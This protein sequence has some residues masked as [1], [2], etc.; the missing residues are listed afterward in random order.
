VK[1]YA[2]RHSDIARAIA[3]LAPRVLPIGAQIAVDGPASKWYRLRRLD[4]PLLAC[5]EVECID[6]ELWAHLSVSGRGHIP[7][8]DQLRW[9][10]ELLLG[11]RKAIQV[12]P[13]KAEYVN[14]N[15]YVLHLYAALEKDPLP[16][17]R[18]PDPL[19]NFGV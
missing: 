1:D 13:P 6:G 12:L 17:F 18:G 11:D 19:G 9:C 16:D 10:K 14:V 8:W 3:E 2:S 4:V 5:L 15:P 7:S